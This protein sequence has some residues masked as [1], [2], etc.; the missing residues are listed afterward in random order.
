VYITRL[1]AA[2]FFSITHLLSSLFSPTLIKESSDILKSITT[3]M[4]LSTLIVL[5]G[6]TL[7]APPTPA[8]GLIGDLLGCPG[9]PVADPVEE[10]KVCM[11]PTI[12]FD[13]SGCSGC[14]VKKRCVLRGNN[15]Y[16]ACY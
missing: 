4:K 13:D 8:R 2:S 16:G 11:G 10:E 5:A 6:L 15:G 7:A 14:T 1:F 12:C 3:T 9:S